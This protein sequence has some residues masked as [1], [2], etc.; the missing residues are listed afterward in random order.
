DGRGDRLLQLVVVPDVRLDVRR[1]R[2]D[3][4]GAV[5]FTDVDATGGGQADLEPEVT[6][7]DRLEDPLVLARERGEGRLEREPDDERGIG[8][9]QRVPDLPRVHRVGPG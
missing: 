9:A 5:V 7:A 4:H 3:D 8:P 2:V 6:V 1:R